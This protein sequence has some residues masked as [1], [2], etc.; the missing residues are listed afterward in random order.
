MLEL[1]RIASSAVFERAPFPVDQTIIIQTLTK[2]EMRRTTLPCL[3][4][5]SSVL[6]SDAVWQVVQPAKVL[7]ARLENTVLL[8]FHPVFELK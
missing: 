4:S 8:R 5:Q 3:R 7:K 6:V 1:Q 2:R